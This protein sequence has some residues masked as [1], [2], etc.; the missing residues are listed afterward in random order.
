MTSVSSTHHDHDHCHGRRAIRLFVD[1]A[2]LE[3]MDGAMY[4]QPL[5][6]DGAELV[7]TTDG[8]RR[9]STQDAHCQQKGE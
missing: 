3:S 6:T 7:Q 9:P 8:S 5:V 2:R 4:R 1:N